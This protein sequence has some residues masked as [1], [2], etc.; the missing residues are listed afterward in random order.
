MPASVCR[1]P[2]ADVGTAGIA[3]DDRLRQR[4][5][6]RIAEPPVFVRS[7]GMQP[8]G[9]IGDVDQVEPHRRVADQVGQREGVGLS[10]LTP[11]MQTYTSM[12]RS[13]RARRA[14]ARP[15]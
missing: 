12:T 3:A 7:R 2:R 8:A 4:A 13:R 9:R 6:Q 10:T 1:R 11:P 15:P 5:G 14:G